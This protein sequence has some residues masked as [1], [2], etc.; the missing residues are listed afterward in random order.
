VPR[1]KKSVGIYT[2]FGDSG[3]TRLGDKEIVS[4]A[5]CRIE[6]IGNVD[7]LNVAIG[8]MLSSISINHYLYDSDKRFLGSLQEDLFVIGK[9][10]SCEDFEIEIERIAL[11]EEKFDEISNILPEYKS[12]VLPCGN[13]TSVHF[14]NLRAICRRAERVIVRLHEEEYVNPRLL[15][16]FNRFSD[17]CFVFSRYY[18]KDEKKVVNAH[19]T[20]SL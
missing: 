15:A 19:N 5:S 7:E 10:L 8:I 4:K 2:R 14:Q 13:I 18:N 9:E 6:A 1:R 16:Y 3:N 11:I 17:L 12:F 20:N